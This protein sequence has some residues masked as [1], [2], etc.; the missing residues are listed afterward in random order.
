M[1]KLDLKKTIAKDLQKMLSEKRTALREFRFGLSGSKT[2][3][4]KKGKFIRKDIARVLTELN[5]RQ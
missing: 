3:N 5:A 2:K 4:V 1:E